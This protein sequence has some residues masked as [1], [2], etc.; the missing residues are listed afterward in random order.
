MNGLIVKIEDEGRREKES[1]LAKVQSGIE[2][3]MQLDRSSFP[4]SHTRPAEE[5]HAQ[6][7]SSRS[8]PSTRMTMDLDELKNRTLALFDLYDN[9]PLTLLSLSDLN[10]HEWAILLLYAIVLFFSFSTNLI[11]I[12]VFTLGRRSRSGLSIFLLNLSVFNII[13]TVY[14][15]P[16]T[17]TSVIFRRWLFPNS[18]CFVLDAFKRFSITGVLLTMI[19][20]A[21]DRYCAV[22]YPLATKL[23]SVRKR[24]WIALAIIWS[25][26]I[27]SA[28]LL[29]SAHSSPSV[30]PRLWV[31]S[32]SLLSEYFDSFDVPIHFSESSKLFS[33]LDF[34]RVDT[35]QCVPNRE[36]RPGEI[37]R[38]ISN[39]LQT[40]FVP[41]F[42]LAFVYL[43]IAGVLWQRSTS[44]QRPTSG[45]TMPGLVS[46]DSIKFRRKLKKVRSVPH[47]L[48]TSTVIMRVL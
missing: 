39:F 34:K 6:L 4:L 12:V 31:N 45:T 25:L 46:H 13:M 41:L 2:I 27:I 19:V 36:G 15:I 38:A 20:I 10:T 18:L 42:I 23:Y 48:I 3:R 9:Y 29:S 40:Y 8:D 5:T 21:I 1:A 43:R 30:I 26:S 22:K 16:F 24:N 33:K 11:A 17:I 14:C 32:R 47:L 7:Y 37:P 35:I 28:V 44:G